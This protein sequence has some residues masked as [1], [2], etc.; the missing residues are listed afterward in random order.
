[1]RKRKGMRNRK[2]KGKRERR[3]SERHWMIHDERV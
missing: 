2:R 3:E 1:M